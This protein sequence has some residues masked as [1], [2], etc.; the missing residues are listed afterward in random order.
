[1]E[2]S[3]YI[4]IPFC[5]RKCIYCD[6]YSAIYD[7]DLAE[8]YISILAN[9]IETLDGRFSTV[10]VGGGTPTVL[11]ADSLKKLLKSLRARMAEPCE[12]T[13]E[14]N[15]ESLNEDKLK[16]L[17]DSGVNRLSIG[18]QSLSDK[19]LKNLGRLHNAAKAAESVGVAAKRGFKN[20]SIDL[21]FG[22]WGEDPAAWKKELSGIA[23]LP[24]AHV[25]CYALTYEKGTPLFLAVK[26]GSVKPLP[27]EVA[28]AMYETAIDTLALAGLKQY[29]VSNFAREGCECRH[30]LNYWENDPYVGLGASAVSYAEG[31][32]ARNISDTAEYI[33]M[34]GSG[35]DIVESS[36]KLSPVRR[37]RETAAVK[38]RTKGGIDSCCFKAKTGF[39][40]FELE[41]R[42]LGGLL[43]EGLIKYKKE[44]GNVT[45]VCLKRKGFLFCDRVSSAFL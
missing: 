12:F 21:I 5:R 2:T 36:E 43:E 11:E 7:R 32:R 42:C 41:K 23:K 4:H 45:G 38:I 1:M 28:A 26:N 33:R 25:S 44:K 24:V 29:E 17:L 22:V 19:K 20:I 18:V 31:L 40:F 34:S 10:Y 3:L 8:A 13:V 35:K 14:A 15:P 27:D 30:N 9:Q 39:D 16:L 6:F 37:A